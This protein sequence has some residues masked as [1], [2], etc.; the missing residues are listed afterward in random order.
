MGEKLRKEML[1]TRMKD[2]GYYTTDT[3]PKLYPIENQFINSMFNDLSIVND[4]I[5]Q[6]IKEYMNNRK[7]LPEDI[8]QY[9]KRNIYRDK[10]TEEYYYKDELI[11]KVNLVNNAIE[12]M[13][14]K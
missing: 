9:G 11:L 13:Y 12:V 10:N 1:E 8:K 6:K 2:K 14:T 3:M 7:L 5:D 4:I